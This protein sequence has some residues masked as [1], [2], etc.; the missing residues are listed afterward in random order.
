[1]PSLGRAHCKQKHVNDQA[2][3]PDVDHLILWVSIRAPCILGVIECG[4]G[5]IVPLWA[6]SEPCCLV[7]GRKTTFIA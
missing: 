6:R 1:M 5:E 4:V 3:G 2:S 7:Y